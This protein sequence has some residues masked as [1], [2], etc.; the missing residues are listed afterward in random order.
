[1]P[2]VFFLFFV[3][4]IAACKHRET[5]GKEILKTDRIKHNTVINKKGYEQISIDTIL[6]IT[7]GFVDNQ[8]F[9]VQRTMQ[10]NLFVFNAKKDTIFKDSTYSNKVIFDDFNKDGYKDIRI[11]YMTNVP[12]IEDL[13]LY[14]KEEKTFKK[15]IGFDE[16]PATSKMAN[17]N[18]Y[19]SYH[20]SGCA[21]MNWTSDLFY[22]DDYKPIKIG[23]IRGYECAD[24]GIKDGIYI[25]K[26]AAGKQIKVKQLKINII[27]NY[28]GY[29]WGFIKNY[30]YKNYKLFL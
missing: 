18:Y 15:V 25:Y 8:R 1:M 12:G 21:D 23:T 20:R 30:W 22:I 28:K 27:N 26:I 13:L 4:L 5:T 17:T 19:Y 24:S 7:N 16:F 3:I 6:E 10:G 11:M 9:T 14:D 29:K 2:K